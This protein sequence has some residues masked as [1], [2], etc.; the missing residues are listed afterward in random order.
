MKY[1]YTLVMLCCLGSLAGR[2]QTSLFSRHWYVGSDVG[3]FSNSTRMIAGELGKYTA[4]NSGIMPIYGL[5]VGRVLAPYASVETGV[6][7]LPLNLVYLYQ[8]DKAIGGKQFNFLT[9][10]LRFNWRTRVFHEQ[11]E[12]HLSGGVHYV[13]TGGEMIEKPFGGLITTPAHARKDSLTYSGGVS[14][15]RRHAANAEVGISFNWAMSKRWTMSVYGRQ[16]IGLMNVAKMNVSIRNN[17]LPVETAEFVSN[18]SGFNAGLSI[19]FNF[20][21]KINRQIAI[22]R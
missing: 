19:R 1:F 5:R 6:Y 20:F 2:G 4:G 12:A 10:P 16:M 15:T 13:W 18:T 7:S 14:V 3:I 21:P 22:S 11:F 17:Q 9:I 8:T